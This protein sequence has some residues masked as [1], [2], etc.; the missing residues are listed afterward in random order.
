M[1]DLTKALIAKRVQVGATTPIGRR[2]SM[3]V[4]QLANGVSPA[5]TVK[6]IEQIQRD[7]WQYVHG[8]HG[9]R[10]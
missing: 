7:G 6:E 9:A 2:L 3:V 8:N 1:N 4:E 5:Q 10:R